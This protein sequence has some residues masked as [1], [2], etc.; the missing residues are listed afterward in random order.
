[1]NPS[2]GRRY[3]L[4]GELDIDLCK[5]CFDEGAN[6]ARAHTNNDP[7]VISGKTLNVNNE[8]MTCATILQMGQ[9]KIAIPSL[10]QKEE[11]RKATEAKK[12]AEL[13]HALDLMDDSDALQAAIKMSMEN[14][15]GEPMMC[16]D[17]GGKSIEDFKSQVFTQL[18]NLSAKCLSA[19]NASDVLSH[20]Y[21][22]YQLVLDLVFK[23]ETEE[24]KAKRGK[25]VA[26]AFAAVVND[27][28]A[29]DS[30]S[31][32]EQK[33]SKLVVC[34]RTLACLVLQRSDL[35]SDPMSNISSVSVGQE[36][37]GEPA[38]NR[39]DKTDPR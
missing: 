2:Q 25:E 19:E 5:Q 12:A 18:L 33:H 11:E 26:L 14:P 30:S 1:M 9:K 10:E 39:K 21:P 36:K 29:G 22:I 4:G 32:S 23:S 3:T 37:D 34:L 38:L 6:F 16:D 35:T 7:V 8:E 15:D 27:S 24:L 28:Y 17:D 31:S 20:S 13:P